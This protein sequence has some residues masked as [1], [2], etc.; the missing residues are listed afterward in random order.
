VHTIQI[1]NG[2]FSKM[3]LDPTYRKEYVA[4]REAESRMKARKAIKKRRGV[5]IR[6]PDLVIHHE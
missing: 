3:I 6:E 4:G 2:H 5:T 1:E